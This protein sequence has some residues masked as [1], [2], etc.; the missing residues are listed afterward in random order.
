MKRGSSPA[1]TSSSTAA[2][3][4]NRTRGGG[5]SGWKLTLEYDGGRNSGWQEQPNART[6]QGELRRA[7]EA[8][9]GEPVE[10]QGAGRTDAGVHAYGQVAHLRARLDR[11]IPPNRLRDE[12]NRELP[13]DVVVLQVETAPANFHARHDAISRR[14]VYQISTRKRAFAK[15]FVWWVRDR[16]DAERM[17]QAAALLVGRHDFVV[18][19][20]EDAARPDESTVVVVSD[21]GID[22][23]DDMIVFRIEASHFLWKMVRR[24][25]GVL[26][27][28]GRGNL[29]RADFES[30]LRGE[31]SAS[32][33]VA[34]WTAPPSGLFLA[35]VRYPGQARRGP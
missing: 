32:M 33:P 23:E 31:G 8:V 18:F 34:E 13:H 17:A 25:V 10:I 15:R 7:A 24:L 3:S 35:E 29:S 14:Y 30:L 20:A 1:R 27:E 28:V 9:F 22:I 12:L 5:L 21:A 6:V 26:V 4:R 2:G 19:R 16:L 11:P